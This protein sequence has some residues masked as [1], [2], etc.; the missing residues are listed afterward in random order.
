MVRNHPLPAGKLFQGI[1]KPLH[2]IHADPQRVPL[3]N[4]LGIDDL[5]IIPDQKRVSAVVQLPLADAV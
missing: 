2:L 4:V 1:R 5:A 3:I